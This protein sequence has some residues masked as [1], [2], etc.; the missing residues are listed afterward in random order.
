MYILP[1]SNKEIYFSTRFTQTN[2]KNYK[3]KKQN[4]TLISYYAEI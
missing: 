4:K 1:M 3:T 2:R